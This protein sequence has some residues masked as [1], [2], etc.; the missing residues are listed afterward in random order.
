MAQFI[1][2]KIDGQKC[3]AKAGQTIFE[4]ARENGIYIPT[5]CHYDGA[6]PVGSCR[7][8]SVMVNKRPLTA[9]STPIGE[10][11]EIENDT[12]ELTDLRKAV[13]EL[14]FTEGNH[15]C[16]SCEK[17]GNCE[18]QAL[19][20]RYQIFAPRFPF[21]FNE[22]NVDASHPKIL[23]D[24]NRCILCKRCVRL[25]LDEQ[26]RQAFTFHK[27]GHNVSVVMDKHIGET[28]TDEMALHSMEVCPV[29]SLLVK[30]KGFTTPIGQRK[31]DKEMIGLENP[32]P[33]NT[34]V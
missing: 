17:S 7:I 15:F 14:L 10:G 27:R 28:M 13:L 5:L 26:G 4:A 19:A 11:M 20:Y 3:M 16:P 31:F 25:V 32:K 8:C 18:L 33:E 21:Q 22:R 30:E 6:K 1:T 9:C 29:G 34:V 2:F 24:R 23:H 12:P